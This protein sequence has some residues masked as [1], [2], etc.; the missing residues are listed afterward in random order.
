[1]RPSALAKRP[2]RSSNG[3]PGIGEVLVADARDHQA[4]GD[5]VDF[6]GADRLAVFQPGAFHFDAGNCGIAK[7]GARG[8]E[9]SNSMVTGFCVPEASPSAAKLRKWPTDLRCPGVQ[10]GVRIRLL[11]QVHRVNVRCGAGE[12]GQFTQFLG[13]HRDLV[14]A[15]PARMTIRSSREV[16]STSSAWATISLPANSGGSAQIRATSSATLPFPIT[17]AVVPVSAGS[18]AANWDEA[19]VPADEGRCAET[20][21]RVSPGSP[22]AGRSGYAGGEHDSVVQVLKFGHRYVGADGDVAD[23]PDIFR[24]G[25]RFVS[26]GHALDR[27]VIGGDAGADRT[28]GHGQPIQRTRRSAPSPQSFCA[29]SAV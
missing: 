12:V 5:R 23:E 2:A 16:S 21:A 6:A 14:R 8:G 24:Q 20:L 25:D 4:G 9:E 10:R 15:A 13:G 28:V 26:L 27:L 11:R 1:M 3:T 19:V 22:A 7:D 18:S 17:T 29:A